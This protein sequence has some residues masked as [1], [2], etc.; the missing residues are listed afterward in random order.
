MVKKFNS[1]FRAVQKYGPYAYQAGKLAYPY[2]RDA[3]VNYMSGQKRTRS[4]TV[5]R[6]SRRVKSTRAYHTEGR[7][8]SKVPRGRRVRITKYKTLGSEKA[9]ETGGTASNAELVSLG[10][11]NFPL[12]EVG[13]SI[14]RAMYRHLLVMDGYDF[15]TWDEINPFNTAA[16]QTRFEIIWKGFPGDTTSA[17]MFDYTV[18]ATHN[19]VC[20]AVW[21]SFLNSVAAVNSGPILV[22]FQY[23][24]VAAGAWHKVH[25]SNAMINVSVRST[26][27]L[28]NRTLG[29]AAG[30]D[31][32]TDVT[33]NPV[34]CRQ[35]VLRGNQVTAA[36]HS[37][38]PTASTANA[39][40]GFVTGGLPTDLE[41]KLQAPTTY[42]YTM[43]S[44]VFRIMP[45]AIKKHSSSSSYHMSVT[46]FFIKMGI[47]IQKASSAVPS[48]GERLPF[49][50]TRFFSFEKLCDTG[51]EQN[52]NI[53]YEINH[54]VSSYMTT[55][56]SMAN[57]IA[58]RV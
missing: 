3:V 29:L 41:S 17:A 31:Q 25:C 36:I 53:G 37:D 13:L 9:I 47:Y 7:H 4:G 39:I 20:Q 50:V 43:G 19:Q 22:L 52:L 58:E 10:Y 26:M 18:A 1:F 15:Q 35:W 56:K 33:N 6:R 32:S 55:R 54:V 16:G 28:Q 30:D 51:G 48:V 23:R 14:V 2:A 24:V 34:I 8:V 40:T 27:A 42:R 11:H 46:N 38:E 49:G 12:Y 57:R 44:N 21:D 45:G 5:R